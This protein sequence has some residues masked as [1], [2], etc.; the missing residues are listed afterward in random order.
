MAKFRFL[1]TAQQMAVANSATTCVAEDFE[2]II[3]VL[4][5]EGY[6]FVPFGAQPAIAGWEIRETLSNDGNV[7]RRGRARDA[8]GRVIS[9]RLWDRDNPIPADSSADALE[10]GTARQGAEVVSDIVET[11]N[12]PLRVPR[13]YARLK[14]KS[15][16]KAK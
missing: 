13:V 14:T 15:A 10:F 6:V 1:T 8:R 2:D 3:G 5:T 4:G 9:V 16:T 12:G 11:I 7:I